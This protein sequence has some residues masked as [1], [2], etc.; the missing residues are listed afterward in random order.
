MLDV[1]AFVSEGYQGQKVTIEVDIRR[2]LPGSEIIG[3]PD[4]AVKESKE[5]VRVSIKNS[6]YE[7]PKER[8]LINLA[9]ANI[10]K[11]GTVFDLAIA[12]AILHQSNQID[13]PSNWRETV[14]ILGE[15]E[16]S[17]RVRKVRGALSAVAQLQKTGIRYAILP[18]ENY[19][20]SS[21]IDNVHICAVS[22]LRE[23]VS[24]L[25]EISLNNYPTTHILR[26]DYIKAEKNYDVNMSDI[27]GQPQVKRALEIAA[28][29][30]H[31]FLLFGPPGCGKTLSCKA[32]ESIL[33]PLSFEEGLEVNQIYSLKNESCQNIISYPPF[34]MPHHLASSEG[35]I[36]GGKHTLPGEISM[37]HN[38]ILFLDEAPEFGK[39][40]L[41][42]LREPLESKRISIT[43]ANHTVWYPADFQLAMAS[44][45]CP[46]GALGRND[47]SCLCTPQ[48]I[49]KYWKRVGGAIL[50]RI[51]IRLAVL[52]VQVD[53]LL[54]KNEED[55]Y[56]IQQRVIMCR[57]IQKERYKNENI[58][59][60]NQ[61]SGNLIEKY[62]TLNE[63]TKKIFFSVMQK[64]TLS[65]RAGHSIL[66]IA[67]TI[68]DMEK[69]SDINKIHLLEAASY[70]R[71]GDNDLYWI[72]I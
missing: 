16:L 32:L 44:N 35:I 26:S 4:S 12:I 10:K 62:C 2:G 68:A 60:N 69:S 34:R 1:C 9:P 39:H 53:K 15:L 64:L 47:R 38:G 6:G 28:S 30:R 25:Q 48:Q 27:K 54:E 72:D 20:E 67:R 8:L 14:L 24:F 22:T 51:D 65:A 17:G 18:T 37:A 43:R 56:T 61:L 58:S 59:T 57:S 3:L 31:H 7:Y 46:C 45:V 11:E 36:G 66:R 40:L 50:D 63:D 49:A 41:Q 33:P 5:R 23:A 42:A 52:P 19:A 21:I 71:Y 29:G 55:S 70:R 13:L